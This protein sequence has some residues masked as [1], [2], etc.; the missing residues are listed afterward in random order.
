MGRADGRGRWRRGGGIGLCSGAGGHD[1]SR[2]ELHGSAGIDESADHDGRLR[3]CG[4]TSAFTEP[5]GSP[6]PAHRPSGKIA[7]RTPETKTGRGSAEDDSDAVYVPAID[8]RDTEISG[9]GNAVDF[10]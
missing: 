7:F 6:A 5:E 9:E 4:M 1:S 2:Q 10:Y 8:E 3:L